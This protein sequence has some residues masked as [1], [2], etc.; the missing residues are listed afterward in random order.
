MTDTHDL[1]QADSIAGD[2]LVH[3][4]QKTND[5]TTTVNTIKDYMIAGRWEDL[6]FPAQGLNPAGSAKPPTIDTSTYPGTLLFADNADNHIG[7][8][9]QMPHAWE[10]GSTISPHIHWSKVTADGSSLDVAWKFRYALCAIGSAPTAFSSWGDHTLVVG[11]LSTLEVQN[12]SIF[13]EID[14]TGYT[15]SCLVLWEIMRD[16]SADTYGDDARLYEF[17]IHFQIDKL[18]SQEKA[19]SES[20]Y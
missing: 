5:K 14:M 10:Y 2:E 11:D 18:G 16:V 15:G 1:N 6:R 12:L 19:P 4:S 17:D 9:A 20:D 7:G 3:I 8:I 13:P